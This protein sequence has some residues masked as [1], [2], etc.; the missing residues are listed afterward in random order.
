MSSQPPSNPVL[1]AI[2]PALLFC[3][4]ASVPSLSGQYADLLAVD[5]RLRMGV[6]YLTQVEVQFSA[7]AHTYAPAHESGEF[8]NGYVKESA[9]Q[10]GSTWNWGFNDSTQIQRNETIRFATTSFQGPAVSYSP[11]TGSAG[12]R[13]DWIPQTDTWGRRLGFSTLFSLDVRR[14]DIEGQTSLPAGF[15]TISK[16][17]SHAGIDPT[18]LTLP[19]A[20]TYD[21]PGALLS[22]NPSETRTSALDNGATIY[23]H[24]ALEGVM[25]SLGAGG[26]THLALTRRLSFFL[27]GQLLANLYL[28][29]FEYGQYYFMDRRYGEETTS[30]GMGEL[31]LGVSGGA[32]LQWRVGDYSAL[33]ISVSKIFSQEL[34]GDESGYNYHLG[35]NDGYYVMAGF[36]VEY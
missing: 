30:H 19:H 20:G 31:L 3:L 5:P 35:F 6:S 4:P 36:Q 29:K 33:L 32:G 14:M 1:Q 27:Q 22:L 12:L 24:M 7:P 8:D 21:G 13:L 17:Y 10:G 28:G 11:R 16:Y 9:Y 26:E 18:L 2:L 23:R 34:D 25:I 15:E